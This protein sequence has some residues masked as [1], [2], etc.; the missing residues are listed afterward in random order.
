M[1]EYLRALH[2]RFF[3]ESE[4]ELE[5]EIDALHHDLIQRLEKP[6]RKTLMCLLN[7]QDTLKCE[8]SI[9]SFAAGF[10]LA[11]GI[12]AE[13]SETPPYSFDEDEVKRLRK[14]MEHQREEE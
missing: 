3:E 11:C 6:E 1:Y 10:R 2:S 7:T 5:Q 8:V 14:V 9:A 4:P 13:L 12:A